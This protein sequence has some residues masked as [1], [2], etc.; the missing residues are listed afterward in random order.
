[1]TALSVHSVPPGHSQEMP[2]NI[3]AI[4][5][6]KEVI[7]KIKSINM[8]ARKAYNEFEKIYAVHGSVW[9]GF[10]VLQEVDAIRKEIVPEITKV[11]REYIGKIRSTKDRSEKRRLHKEKT[12]E[13]SKLYMKIAKFPELAEQVIAEYKRFAGGTAPL[14]KVFKAKIPKQSHGRE[15]YY[16]SVD[17]LHWCFRSK[18]LIMQAIYLS[19]ESADESGRIDQNQKKALEFQ[20][21]GMADRI[22]LFHLRKRLRELSMKSKGEK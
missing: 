13:E 5:S 21:H 12:E 18:Y 8:H 1:M 17:V 3:K 2:D 6:K 10:E 19:L 7:D 15:G 20:R 11:S 22:R 9:P 14:I 4:G 16:K